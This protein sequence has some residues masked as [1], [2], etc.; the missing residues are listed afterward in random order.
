MNR[1]QFSLDGTS[2]YYT[3]VYNPTEIRTPRQNSSEYISTIPAL[4]GQGIEFEPYF[5]T[6][7]GY[8]KWVGYPNNGTT[9]A[10][11]FQTQL[12]TL[13]TI[14]SSSAVYMKLGDISSQFLS[15]YLDWT[16][17]KIIAIDRVTRLGSGLFY[18]N[19]TM[20]WREAE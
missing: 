8:M 1:I 5:N 2:V 18:D 14:K 6:V 17:I 13:E 15:E 16:K 7:R 20:Y 3:L 19:V 10:T 4:D 11:N 12:S 9:L